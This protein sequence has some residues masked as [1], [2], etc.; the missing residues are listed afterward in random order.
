MKISSS[1]AGAD[2]K[3]TR[4]WRAAALTTPSIAAS[5]AE[6]RRTRP[7]ACRTRTPARA[8]N[9][10]GSTGDAN[11]ISTCRT[12]RSRSDA[13]VSTSIRRPA[14]MI[15]TRCA[16]CCTSSS[17]WDERKTVRPSAAVSRS[18]RRNSSCRSGSRPLVG[19][20]RMRSSGRC[21]NACTTPELLPVALRQLADRP[22]ERDGEAL[23]ELF[24]VGPVDVAA[25][26]GQGVEL[27][28]AGQ[29]VVE[30]EVAREVADVTSRLHAVRTSV[31]AEQ[32][33]SAR[34]RA[35]EV[36]QQADRGALAGAVRTEEAEDLAR[37]RPGGPCPPAPGRRR[38]T[39]SRGL[40][41]RSQAH[42]PSSERN[43]GVAADPVRPA[44][45]PARP[46]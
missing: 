8:E 14:R 31:P 1:S 29:A 13:T 2:T 25:Q 28:A 20:S 12:A 5:G 32:R 41:C 38:G 10:A 44:R 42:R 16:A 6:S 40:P 18:R 23:D 26:A 34:R 4:S 37:A 21:M 22:V 27:L 36:E 45:P 3:S 15:P 7:S 17:E 35:D 39:S 30:P 24:A 19:S 9:G 33:G 46:A 11:V 43:R